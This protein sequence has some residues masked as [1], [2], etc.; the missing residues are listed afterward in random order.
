MASTP[1]PHWRRIAD[2]LRTQIATGEI[3][4]GDYIPSTE[5]LTQT[6]GVSVYPV[7]QAVRQLTEE[8]LLES[9]ST[10][11]VRVVATPQTLEEAKQTIHELSTQL[12]SLQADHARLQSVVQELYRRLD[13]PY[14]EDTDGG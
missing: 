7:R 14:P 2:D 9:D 3:P 5:R 10:K 6:H 13:E 12:T 1:G 8:G 4:V 11:G